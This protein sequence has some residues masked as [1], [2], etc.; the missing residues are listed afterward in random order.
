MTNKVLIEK[1]HCVVCR[2]NKS[3]FLK[4]KMNEQL[5]LRVYKTLVAS[6]V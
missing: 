1:S 4:Q 5:M 3:I 2:S 6:N